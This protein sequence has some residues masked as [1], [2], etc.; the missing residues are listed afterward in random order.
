[1]CSSIGIYLLLYV[2]FIS[3]CK[4]DDFSKQINRAQVFEAHSRDYLIMGS[5]TSGVLCSTFH[6]KG[7]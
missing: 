1:M 5:L 6:P 7:R 2:L 4:L 3:M